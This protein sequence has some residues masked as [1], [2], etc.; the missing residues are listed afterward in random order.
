MRGVTTYDIDP[1]S[2]PC[3]W[4][5]RLLACEIM[6]FENYCIHRI[7]MRGASAEVNHR[8]ATVESIAPR[9]WTILEVIS[10]STSSSR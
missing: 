8:K 3:T 9:H 1:F 10:T 7:D 2:L 4:L 5:V 6:I